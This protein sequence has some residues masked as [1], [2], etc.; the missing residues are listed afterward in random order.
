MA[1]P[2][3][4]PSKKASADVDAFL[5][6]MQHPMRS[7]IGTVRRLILASDPRIGE[8]IKWN[9]VSFLT[10]DFFATL[11]NPNNPRT[12]DHVALLLH[13]GA[14]AKG[15]DMRSAVPDPEH[16][17]KWIAPDRGM[18]I[19][20]TAEDVSAKGKALQAIVRAWIEQLP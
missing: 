20:R 9:G 11:N 14:K 13:T 10:T 7:Q 6:A 18:V 19:F 4:S 8:A 15:L 16:L 1:A 5:A 2:G 3:R 17:V 12:M